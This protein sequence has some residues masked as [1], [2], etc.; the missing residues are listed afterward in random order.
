MRRKII[1]T[2]M[3]GIVVA[4]AVVAVRGISIAKAKRKL[5]RRRRRRRRPRKSA[6]SLRRGLGSRARWI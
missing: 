3:V 6:W 2:I 4:G 1:K 5:R